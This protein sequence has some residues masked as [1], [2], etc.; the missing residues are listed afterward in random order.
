M[1]HSVGTEDGDRFRT[2]WGIARQNG[3]LELGSPGLFSV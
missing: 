1:A 2:G 3:G